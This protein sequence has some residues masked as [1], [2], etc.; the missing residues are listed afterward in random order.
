MDEI[1]IRKVLN[2][3]SDSFRYLIRNYKDIAY[4]LAMSVVKDEYVAQ[5]VVQIAFVK[6]FTKLSNFK[7]KSKFSTWLYRI[8]INEAFNAIR[9]R[10]QEVV[11]FEGSPAFTTPEIDSFS[12]EMDAD[13]QRY[14]INEALKMISAKESLV[15]RLFY[16]EENSI[17]EITAITG[18]TASNIKVLLHRGR[19]NMKVILMKQLNTNKQILYS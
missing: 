19:N 2:G 15:L 17:D 10:K 13:E 12:L 8:V 18:W 6:A 11:S 9:K 5:E 1:Y 16:L 14:Y 7:G 4:S 3:D